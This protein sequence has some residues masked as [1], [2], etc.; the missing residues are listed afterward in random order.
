MSTREDCSCRHE[1]IAHVDMRIALVDMI[2]LLM[3]TRE[4]C[5]C[6]HERIAHVDMRGL[7]MST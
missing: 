2:G 3:S 7:L 5:S 6:R 4:D 1:R